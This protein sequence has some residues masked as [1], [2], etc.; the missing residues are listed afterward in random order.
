MAFTG[1]LTNA[2]I[3]ELTRAAQ[4]SGLFQAPRELLLQGIPPAFVATLPVGLPPI[5]QFSVDLVRVSQ[6]ERMTGGRVPI[7]IMLRNAADRL[8]LLDR[9]EA[10]VF[11]RILSQVTNV[12]AGLPAL[13]DPGG[14]PEVISNQQIIGTNDMVDIAFLAAGL[15]IAEA[16]ALIS[17]PRF[18]GS[19]QVQAPDGAPWISSGTAW[20]IA[21]GLAIT[22]HHVINARRRKEAAADAADLERQALGASLKFDF[23]AEKAC[24]LQ[25]TATRLVAWSRELDYALLAVDGPEG[26]LTPRIAP[27]LVEFARTSRLTVNIVQHPDTGHKRVAF[28]NNLIS[29]ADATTIRYYTDTD[30]GSSGAPVCDDQ[31]QVVALHRG[32]IYTPGVTFLGKNEAYVNFGS[33]I[34]AILAHLRATAPTAAEAVEAGQLKKHRTRAGPGRPPGTD[35]GSKCRPCW[36]AC[37]QSA[38]TPRQ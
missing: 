7:I 19:Q 13:P 32:S 17:V 6:V 37:A 3:N 9:V 21:P 24:G 15:D 18:E 22:N 10:Q 28:R 38:R 2:E 5:D 26:R 14:L 20:L 12:A 23:N 36:P 30:K 34:Q 25:A 31:W 35:G 33:Q 27:A 29:A 8:Q 1:Y 4:S 11:E 16:V